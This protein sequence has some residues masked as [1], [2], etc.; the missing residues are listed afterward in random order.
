MGGERGGAATGEGEPGVC[1]K[2]T[3]WLRQ[4]H[5]GEESARFI[6]CN[7]FEGDTYSCMSPPSKLKFEAKTCEEGVLF[8]IIHMKATPI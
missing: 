5:P 3:D 4:D 8:F 6:H 2:W 7:L 1:D